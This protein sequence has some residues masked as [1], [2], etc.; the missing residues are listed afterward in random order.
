VRILRIEPHEQRIGL[1]SRDVE[2]PVREPAAGG[3]AP[4][5]PAQ[6]AP[7]EAVKGTS[8]EKSGD[9]QESVETDEKAVPAGTD[10]HE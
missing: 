9:P 2:Q 1:S 8:R 5:G 6:A 4:A 7:K 3:E 10:P